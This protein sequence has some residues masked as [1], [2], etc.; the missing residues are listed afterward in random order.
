[1][2]LIETTQME[3]Y[4]HGTFVCVQCANYHLTVLL[5]SIV[6]NITYKNLQ[7]KKV[8]PFQSKFG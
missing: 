2:N 7:L 1:M 5:K 8:L 3:I 4:V 6:F